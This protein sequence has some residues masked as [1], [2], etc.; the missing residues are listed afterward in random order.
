MYAA[1]ESVVKKEKARQDKQAGFPGVN[2]EV[3]VKD[4]K[5]DLHDYSETAQLEAL[6][7]KNDRKISSSQ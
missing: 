1:M 2:D 4:K 5:K 7:S 6:K 3:K